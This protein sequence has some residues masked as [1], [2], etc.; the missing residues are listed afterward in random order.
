MDKRKREM[1]HSKGEGIE[2]LRGLG[3]AKKVQGGGGFEIFL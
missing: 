1:R 3:R 2:I